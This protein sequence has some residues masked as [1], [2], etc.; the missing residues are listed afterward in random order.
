MD[1]SEQKYVRLTT[2]TRD[3]RPKHTPVWVARWRGDGLATTT[4]ADSWKIKRLQRTSRVELT[5]SDG[6]G[7]VTE[8]VDASSGSAEIVDSANPDFRAME[9]TLVEKYG[10]QYRLFR[11]IRKVR[12]KSACGIAITLEA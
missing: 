12:G 1:I 8:G 11:L 10:L 3:G 5:P 4:D 9:D 2:F 7:N 6:R